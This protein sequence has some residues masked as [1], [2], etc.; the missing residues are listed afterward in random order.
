MSRP[1]EKV[2][3]THRV[4][5]PP[6]SLAAN[7]A[8]HRSKGSYVKGYGCS[9]LE[10]PQQQKTKQLQQHAPQGAVQ[11]LSS[12]PAARG[13]DC[14]SLRQVRSPVAVVRPSHISV[15]EDSCDV[16]EEDNDMDVS[17]QTTPVQSYLPE[18]RR[19]GVRTAAALPTQV[20]A[21][22]SAPR[23]AVLCKRTEM[24]ADKENTNMTVGSG[25]TPASTATGAAAVAVT[26]SRQVLKTPPASAGTPMAHCRRISSSKLSEGAGGGQP[27]ATST[28][29]SSAGV[30]AASQRITTAKRATSSKTGPA[31]VGPRK[32]TSPANAVTAVLPSTT[33]PSAGTKKEPTMAAPAK[34]R[35]PS[36]E[37]DWALRVQLDQ[38]DS[39][40]TY[41]TEVA[42]ALSERRRC[43]PPP[44]STED[45]RAS[46]VPWRRH[47][48]RAPRSRPDGSNWEQDD[49]KDLHDEGSS[50]NT[51]TRGSVALLPDLHMAASG[52]LSAFTKLEYAQLSEDADL[53]LLEKEALERSSQLL[54]LVG[55]VERQ[56]SLHEAPEVRHL[57]ADRRSVFDEVHQL[58][59][60]ISRMTQQ[61]VL[62]HGIA[63]HHDL[64]EACEVW[65][66]FKTSVEVQEES[67][68]Q[69][70]SNA[71]AGGS[72]RGSR[73]VGTLSAGRLFHP[74]RMLHASPFFQWLESRWFPAM[75]AWRQL[76]LDARKL[77]SK[78]DTELIIR[79][80]RQDALQI[81]GIQEI[82]RPGETVSALHHEQIVVP[83]TEL[84]RKRAQKQAAMDQLRQV[85]ADEDSASSAALAKALREA[86]A[87]TQARSGR[88]SDCSSNSGAQHDDAALVER[89][90][91]AL[92]RI[93]EVE[94]LRNA[95]AA[96][97]QAPSPTLETLLEHI[98][99]ANEILLLWRLPHNDE[100]ARAAIA[101]GRSALE[102]VRAFSLSPRSQLH[103]GRASNASFSRQHASAPNAAAG[104][105]LTGGA[106][107][108][109][110]VPP[111]NLSAINSNSA[112][113]ALSAPP[114]TLPHAATAA[115]IGDGF[116]AGTNVHAL[117]VSH[118]TAASWPADFD[119]LYRELCDVFS[120]RFLQL[121]A[122]RQ[123]EQALGQTPE[124]RLG[125]RMSNDDNTG[126]RTPS[127]QV[128]PRCQTH[129]VGSPV[130]TLRSSEGGSLTITT[131]RSSG[132]DSRWHNHLHLKYA[133]LTPDEL[134]RCI[135][136]AEEAGVSVALVDEARARLRRLST[137]RLKIHFDAQTRVLPVADAARAKFSD[138]YDQLHAH[139]QAQLAQSSSS[140]GA[141]GAASAWADRRL[142]IRYEDMDGDFIS[143][144]NQQDWDV[145]LSELL[146]QEGGSGR[147]GG[148]IE[149]F[150]DYPI[151]PS[152]PL[153]QQLQQ[154][155]CNE[156]RESTS[157]TGFQVDAGEC[158]IAAP[159]AK[160]A[161][162]PEKQ[163]NVF[164][165]LASL[166]DIAP[167]TQGGRG[168]GVSASRAPRGRP[169]QGG[170]SPSS[171][172][173]ALVTRTRSAA[174]AHVSRR[175]PS[176]G[177]TGMGNDAAKPAAAQRKGTSESS[178]GKKMATS[179]TGS[180]APSSTVQSA[181]LT[182]DNLRRNIFLSSPSPPS[183]GGRGSGED[184]ARPSGGGG[185]A[186]GAT[187]ERKSDSKQE[188]A[189]A[190]GG[191]AAMAG[192]QK[193]SRGGNGP[194]HVA[195]ET[196]L[197]S[198]VPCSAINLNIDA[199]R[200]WDAASEDDFQLLEI[201][202]RASVST[203]RMDPC[204]PNSRLDWGSPQLSSIM[205]AAPSAGLSPSVGRNTFTTTRC[206]GV[207]GNN[208]NTVFT[209]AASDQ[210][211][212]A[213]SFASMAVAG[214][215]T[216]AQTDKRGAEPQAVQDEGKKRDRLTQSPPRCAPRRW[217][218]DDFNL[219]EVET[220]CSD[221]SRIAMMPAVQRGPTSL[222]PRPQTPSR[223]T[224]ANRTPQ[225]M[226]R[227]ARGTPTR[228]RPDSADTG[229]GEGEDGESSADMFA[230]MQ[231]MRDENTRAMAQSRKAVW[232]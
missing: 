20:P 4:V 148:R 49:A 33:A 10:Q 31:T 104:A 87:Y 178:P 137:V 34:Q 174:G 111:L 215:S 19:R 102:H 160:T 135:Q 35:T 70:S 187:Q 94:H 14:G 96:L 216:D 41:V 37:L 62:L 68:R 66:S 77:A 198:G 134:R 12:K 98:T 220:V 115:W 208:R 229:I 58:V 7:G 153:P 88:P 194:R 103:S 109:P 75:G 11:S 139:C 172:P 74:L 124:D 222:P 107:T 97:M 55:A 101:A 189:A 183:A 214:R 182:A 197:E 138:V 161:T 30:S 168:A 151:M 140:G 199:A 154:S 8:R 228:G 24:N 158:E 159:A 46:V 60:F 120:V 113:L 192:E 184:T 123:L 108:H 16:N 91:D 86:Q 83:V 25:A 227:G 152:T 219:D 173:N 114:P 117:F 180:P 201:Q 17:S 99:R 213:S 6:P 230:E 110:E 69:I 13:A 232:H 79:R 47:M 71:A 18:H 3:G 127:Q 157:V 57:L 181:E 80:S 147:T 211:S 207:G 224:A 205:T 143:L 85:M 44:D 223:G 105:G 106:S 2:T 1:A 225:R 23:T 200:R 118:T 53:A 129:N 146:P 156:E 61:V 191:A 63:A 167:G 177:K 92:E 166:K 95:M 26:H 150:C 221:R 116:P 5:S 40:L 164:K 82:L 185:S 193:A 130:A 81:A 188:S 76:V 203:I 142:R 128:T 176:P 133:G 72:K 210:A 218:S 48:G 51:N 22:S 32:A 43:G 9:S 122:Q 89:A 42:C 141:A 93:Q 162:P 73:P 204:L 149:L 67:L 226:R 169:R 29:L 231:R 131:A 38:A 28:P 27:T 126:F 209:V 52:L 206:S 54:R 39:V 21:A 163:P 64:L 196:P 112:L 175:V 195:E 119:A 217:S 45:F 65:E 212:K 202:T 132:E 186:K 155:T 165:R 121:Q 78:G 190:D 170:P 144:L 136:Q 179:V 90:E 145:M 125:T 59:D 84:G 50:S 56:L 15:S 171:S 36:P 100:S